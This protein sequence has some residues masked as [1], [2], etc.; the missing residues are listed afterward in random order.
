MM[1]YQNSIGFFEEMEA[2]LTRDGPKDLGGE[3]D[4]AHQKSSKLLLQR[5]CKEDF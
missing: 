1:A 5:A 4:A 2:I 3:L